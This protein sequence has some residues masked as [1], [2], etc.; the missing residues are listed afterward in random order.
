M[1]TLNSSAIRGVDYDEFTRK[2]TIY[3]HS[4][5]GYTFNGVPWEIYTGLISSSSPGAYYN[6][7]IRGRYR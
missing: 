6:R 2:M 5:G 7:H 3:F 4:S 1:H